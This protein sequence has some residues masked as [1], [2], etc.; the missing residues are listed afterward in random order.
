MSSAWQIV[1]LKELR[2]TLRDRRTLFVMIVVPILLYPGMLVISEQLLL[3][4]RRSLEAEVARVA[5]VGDAP[6]ELRALVE[7]D[8]DLVLVEISTEATEAVRDG[9]VAA[10]AVLG[11]AP[12]EG[13][14]RSATVLYDG[15]SER[16]QR[17][18]E[19]L[20]GVLRQWR[21]SLL[22]RRL[23]ERGLPPGFAAPV[24]VADSSVALPGEVGGYAL[25]RILPLLLVVITLLGAFYPAID[26]AAGEKERGTLETL[27][28]APVPASQIVA[29]KF[30]T[31]AVVGLVAAAL[32]L[33]SMLLTFQTGL[34][35]VTEAI[36]LEVSLP[37]SAVAAIFVML[38]PLAV[39]FGALFLGVAVRSASFKEAQNALT[40]VYVLVLVP[41]ML[42]AFPG[43]DFG[44]LFAVTPVAGVAFLFRDVLEGDPSWGLGA[45]VLGSTTLYALAALAFASRSFGSERVLFGEGEGDVRGSADLRAEATAPGP[46]RAPGGPAVA[47]PAR[48]THARVPPPSVAFGFVAVLGVLFFYGGVRLQLALGEVG[49]LAGEWL[50]LFAPALALVVSGRF[51]MRGTL[52]LR[53]PTAPSLAGAV[54]LAA[55]ALPTVW[56]VG[57]LQTFVLPIPWDLLEGLERL[58]TA[59]SLPRLLWLIVLLALT[60][61]LCEE[62]VFRGVLLGGTRSLGVARAV[63]L[64][65]LVFGA[66]HLSLETAI[67][68]LPTA[69]LGMLIAWAVLRT[70]SIWV[71]SLMHF[72]NN[73]T[74][75]ALSSVPALRE[76]LSDPETP[77]PVWL[78]PL[79]ALALVA[80]ARLLEP[81]RERGAAEAAAS[82]LEGAGARADA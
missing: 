42:P 72:L 8:E 55:G 12:P 78:V 73:G 68:F 10:A 67:R 28:T 80:G 76:A 7:A 50:L 64:N 19:E 49:L 43:I 23:V 46:R 39:L 17:G 38:V 54:L 15:A 29:G 9:S 63:L 5:V 4:G 27:L 26:L 66:F 45:L 6:E 3:F 52:S 37:L 61:A 44:A 16:S 11:P 65:G 32:N 33:G 47:E 48:P 21:D 57:W 36:G 58:V 1:F 22:A 13:G 70:G 14:T 34:L 79:G 2:E 18:R 53:K 75:V 60:P 71:G 25:G 31:V 77:P 40:P 82:R 35:Q 30:L 20:A 69:L 51:S 81:S 56:L 74:I 41:A 24:A 62:I 59:D